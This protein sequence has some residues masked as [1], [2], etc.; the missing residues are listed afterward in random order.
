MSG[1]ALA[2]MIAV[3]GTVVFGI[4]LLVRRAFPRVAELDPGPASS[5]LSYVAAAYGVLVGFAI[6]FLL[7]QVASARQAIGDE[8]TSIG[9]A[10]DEAQLFPDGEP[11]IQHALICYSRAV[12]EREWP[13]LA[14]GRSAP[15]ADQAYR[16]LVET[17]GTVQEPT[18]GTFQPA[19]ATN[20]FVQIGGISTARATRLVAA[21]VRVGPLMWSLLI[22]GALLAIGLIFLLTAKANPVG[23]AIFV[24]LAGIFTTVMLLIVLVLSHPFRDATTALEPQLITENT[25]RMVTLAPGPAAEPCSFDA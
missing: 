17:Y 8:A 15:E 14:D 19:A 24:G 5:T 16:E 3:V 23:Q 9:T 11:A 21:E 2:V 13:A 7:G 22:G 6:V 12:T 18:T 4:S 25:T 1:A 20:S 10:F